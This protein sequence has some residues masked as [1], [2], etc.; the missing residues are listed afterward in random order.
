[1]QMKVSKAEPG[2]IPACELPVGSFA[3][4]LRSPQDVWL[5]VTHEHYICFTQTR[6][7]VEPLLYSLGEVGR[8][9][10]EDRYP[11][12][13]LARGSKVEFLI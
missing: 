8:T 7:E 12:V 3:M 6:S 2:D 11:L 4:E 5:R 9:P 1:M 13:P 10:E